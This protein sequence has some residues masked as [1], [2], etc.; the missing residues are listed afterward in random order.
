MFQ[1]MFAEMNDLLSDIARQLPE[2]KGARRHELLDKYRMLRKL[3][4]QALDEWLAF[5]E[6]LSLFRQ[7]VE[8][9]DEPEPETP[10][11]GA[12]SGIEM[13]NFARGQGYY[14]LLMFPKCI[15]QFSVVIS[16]YPDNL[17]ARLYLAMSHL[18]QGEAVAA[19]VH[20]EHMLPRVQS[21]K[22]K[23][24]LYNAV[25]CIAASGRRFDE[26][27]ELFGLALKYDPALPE[28]DANLEV[29]RRGSG[30]LQIGQQLVS[31][32]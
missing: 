26:A 20:L 3:S 22:L 8:L 11:G 6:A 10:L 25:G 13:E 2:A 1:Q 30:E 32:L 9:T 27:K 5:A 15:E 31:L 21:R 28:P 17:A 16:H 29:C 19:R 24:N 12:D 18:H 4:D 7:K 14:K 23:A